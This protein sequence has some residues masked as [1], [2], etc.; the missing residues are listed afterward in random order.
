MRAPGPPHQQRRGRSRLVLAAFVVLFVAPLPVLAQSSDG[1]FVSSLLSGGAN[2]IAANLIYPVVQLLGNLLIALINILVAVASYNDFINA[3]AVEKG[4]TIVRDVANMFF[5]VVLLVIAFGTVLNIQTY[6]YNRLLGRLIIMAFLVNFARFIAGIFIDAA[7]V[8]MLTFVNAFRHA[9]AGNLTTA[10]GIEDLLRLRNV[11][12]SDISGATIFGAILLAL[13]LVLIAVI[14]VGV[15]V[16][17]L[18]IRIIALW[19]LVVLSPLAFVLRTFPAG[20]KYASEW[21]SNFQKYVICGPVIAFFLWLALTVMAASNTSLLNVNLNRGEITG[22]SGIIQDAGEAAA[23]SIA[24]TISEISRA[25]N[26]LSYIVAI[27]LLLGSLMIAQELCGRAGSIAGQWL[28]KATTAAKFVTGV[29]AV[30]AALGYGREKIQRGWKATKDVARGGAEAAVMALPARAWRFY[31][32]KAP[33]LLNPFGL[34]RGW[35]Q[36]RKEQAERTRARAT[37]RGQQ[38]AERFTTSAVSDIIAPWT[39]GRRAAEIAAKMKEEKEAGRRGAAVRGVFRGLGGYLRLPQRER[40]EAAIEQNFAKEFSWMSKEQM[41]DMAVKIERMGGKDGQSYRRALL[42]TAAKNGYL[43]DIMEH[44]HFLQQYAQKEDVYDPKTKK[45]YQHWGTAYSYDKLNQFMKNYIGE[46][47]ESLQTMDQ[48]GELGKSIGHLEYYGHSKFD[49]KKGRFTFRDFADPLLRKEAMQA[50]H[51]EYRKFDQRKAQPFQVHSF[52]ELGFRPVRDVEGNLVF[53]KDAAGNLKKDKDGNPIPE[54]VMGVDRLG[55]F[56]EE[57]LHIMSDAADPNQL[58]QHTNGRNRGW[59]AFRKDQVTKVGDTGIVTGD[60]KDWARIKELQ[61]EYGNL[62][63]VA[64]QTNTPP[65][66]EKIIFRA[67]DSKTGEWLPEDLVFHAA[68]PAA[69]AAGKGKEKAEAVDENDDDEL[70][71]IPATGAQTAEGP[72]GAAVAGIASFASGKSNILGFNANAFAGGKYRDRAGLYLSNPEAVREYAQE[73]GQLLD[74]QISELEQSGADQVRLGHLQAARER[75]RDPN[76]LRGIKL[77]NTARRGYS[78]RHVI[79][80]EGMHETLDTI[81]PDG[82]FLASLRQSLSPDEQQQIVQQMREKMGDAQMSES[83]AFEEYLAEG[84]ANAWGSRADT[85]AD[86][87]K[88]RGDLLQRVQAQVAQTRASARDVADAEIPRI[89]G[90][91]KETKRKM[92]DRRQREVARRAEEVGGLQVPVSPGPR[93]VADDLVGLTAERQTADASLAQAQRRDQELQENLSQTQAQLT[94]RR[95]SARAAGNEGL[96][97]RYEQDL[98]EVSHE[99]ESSKR[100]VAELQGTHDALTAREQELQAQLDRELQAV[101]PPAPT[102]GL[103]AR[104]RPRRPEPPRPTPAPAPTVAAGPPVPPPAAPGDELADLQRKLDEAEAAGRDHAAAQLRD[105]IANYVPRPAAPPSPPAVSQP[106]ADVIPPARQLEY[107]PGTTLE[108]FFQPGAPRPERPTLKQ[109]PAPPGQPAPKRPPEPRREEPE[110]PELWREAQERR[111]QAPGAEAEERADA[112]ET[113]RPALDKNV[114]QALQAQTEALM[115]ALSDSNTTLQAIQDRLT[116]LGRRVDESSRALGRASAQQ[117]RDALGQLQAQAATHEGPL[118]GIERQEWL[119]RTQEFYEQFRQHLERS[120]RRAALRDKNEQSR[121]RP[122]EPPP[123]PS[124]RRVQP[125]PP[126]P[127]T[128]L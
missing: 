25:D 42:L 12:G 3:T 128:A 87:V 90:F 122:T 80:H 26:L 52:G 115:G 92:E 37:A 91:S 61:Q 77:V 35:K 19:L 23:G 30:G 45:T 109:P 104:P 51:T 67:R 28:G 71:D 50:A 54:T 72:S 70:R 63:G 46:S 59:L 15:Y 60:E 17:V 113:G 107:K 6:R 38:F 24:G 85:S 96:A 53:K 84:L 124:P 62:A 75:L 123:A 32:E 114:V 79:A 33:A 74:Q 110:P 43:D 66:V 76:A 111:R 112:P 97:K 5:I 55:D 103:Q 117:L 56:G 49:E 41:A 40:A 88:L 27:L 106:P 102:P 100:R 11:K 125:P 2:F 22:S 65:G 20:Q 4:F 13:A 31:Q 14:V 10:F 95:D 83:K 69:A 120:D 108:A 34:V 64:A 118:S 81:D 94:Q 16:V 39:W 36:M 98:E 89:R 44:E 21:W 121:P 9:A 29:T 58:K 82:R 78:A 116:D 47:P 101:T 68:A 86:A 57:S 119:Q 93:R 99:M 73:Y 8:V 18:L 48:I 1:G 127:S 7:Q 105:A 126:P